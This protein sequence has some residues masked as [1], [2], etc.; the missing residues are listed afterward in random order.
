LKIVLK[1][2]KRR[3]DA[4][5]GYGERRNRNYYVRRRGKKRYKER[6]EELCR[7]EFLEGMPV[8]LEEKWERIKQVIYGA[9]VKKRIRKKN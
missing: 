8:S 9:L 6:T 7:M 2:R 4:E 1:E 3:S 5:E